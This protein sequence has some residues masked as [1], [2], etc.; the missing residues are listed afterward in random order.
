VKKEL[1]PD[2][3]SVACD[4][5]GRTILKG[6][7]TEAYL[8]PGGKRNRVCELC[9]DRAERHGWIRET[10]AG[11][12]PARVPRH[13]PRRPL[14]S[15]FRRRAAKPPPSGPAERPVEEPAPLEGDMDAGNGAEPL[16][17]DP[18]SEADVGMPPPR[19]QFAKEPRHV[20]AVPTTAEVKVERALA[21]FNGSEHQRMVAGLARTLGAPWVAAAP[22][23]G[24]PSAVDVIVAWELS[25]YRFRVDLGDEAGPVALLDKGEQLGE[26]GGAERDW[27]AA[28]DSQ[29]RLLPGHALAGEG[30]EQ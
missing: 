19:R 2:Y 23:E 11:D 9:F 30:A 4:V 17:E 7:R 5:C 6:E 10:A 29:G 20:R 26:V 8:A 13:E 1:R 18:P 21:L 24:Q 22:D 16:E 3:E 12:A 14:L 15:R 25:W 28:M 27:N